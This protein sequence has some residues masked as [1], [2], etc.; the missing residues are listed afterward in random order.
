MKTKSLLATALLGITALAGLALVY[1]DEEASENKQKTAMS[2]MPAAV[3]KTIQDNLAGGTV[4]ETAKETK[5]G[6]TYYEA[7]VQKSGGEE[8]EIKVD[9]DGKLIS[10]G[11]EEEDNEKAEED[12]D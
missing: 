6:K 8:I 12:N 3:Q 4:T 2:E 11:K 5:E 10:A 7:K 1:A 9:P